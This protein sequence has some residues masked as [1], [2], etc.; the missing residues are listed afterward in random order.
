MNLLKYEFM[1]AAEGSYNA[2]IK[3]LVIRIRHNRENIS[4]DEFKVA[5][6][7][8]RT[9]EEVLQRIDEEIGGEPRDYIDEIMEELDREGQVEEQLLE[10]IER[11]AKA[12]TSAY[13]IEFVLD[14][15][16]F[17]LRSNEGI[18]WI[19][20]F[21]YK[22]NRDPNLTLLMLKEVFRSACY[23]FD[24]TFVDHCPESLAQRLSGR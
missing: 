8:V 24:V 7:E 9:I 4:I 10:E 11:S 5:M 14:D 2:L 21:G 3:E 23:K 17:D 1:D 20:F 19:E 6:P 16:S 12:L 18:F 15:F 13:N 22:V